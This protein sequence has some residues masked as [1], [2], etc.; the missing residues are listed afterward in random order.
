MKE[1]VTIDGVDAALLAVASRALRQ[2][3]NP[4]HRVEQFECFQSSFKFYLTAL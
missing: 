3:E 2:L 4:M 1:N